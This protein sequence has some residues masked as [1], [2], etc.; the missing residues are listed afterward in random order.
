MQCTKT[1][2]ILIRIRI[3]YETVLKAILA[4]FHSIAG[5]TLLKN[6]VCLNQG[7]Q[8]VRNPHGDR[9]QCHQE[10]ASHF[11]MFL[12]KFEEL[13][14]IL[15]CSIL[16]LSYWNVYLLQMGGWNMPKTEPIIGKR[17]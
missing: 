4:F 10:D 16:F 5:L 6:K 2:H 8:S 3:V 9:E 1:L 11:T 12:E 14:C 7:S 15:L 13:Q 17:L